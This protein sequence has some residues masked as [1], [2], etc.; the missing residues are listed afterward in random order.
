MNH[1]LV[2]NKNIFVP[3]KADIIK[4]DG[5]VSV[6][7]CNWMRWL[8][9]GN[10]VRVLTINCK[11]LNEFDIVNTA[12]QIVFAVSE[13]TSPPFHANQGINSRQEEH[14]FAHLH[15][16][17]TD[18]KIVSLYILQ[19]FVELLLFNHVTSLFILEFIILWWWWVFNIKVSI[20]VSSWCLF[21]SSLVDTNGCIIMTWS[22]KNRFTV[23][24]EFRIFLR[25]LVCVL[26]IAFFE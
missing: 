23:L 9:F 7:S 12:D 26:K 11:S 14:E 21:I 13:T 17:D 3:I 4:E 16:A 2:F 20:R 15:K 8:L 6:D 18:F 22:M 5:E 19:R 24:I 10:I 25:Y 1:V